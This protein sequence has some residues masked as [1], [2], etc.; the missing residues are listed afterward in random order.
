MVHQERQLIKDKNGSSRF[1]QLV[2]HE[3]NEKQKALQM[4]RLAMK[5]KMSG[6][7]VF[8]VQSFNQTGPKRKIS[9]NLGLA[10]QLTKK[11]S[12]EIIENPDEDDEGVDSPDIRDL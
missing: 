3:D 11:H 2:D 8:D 7:L 1:V 4:K 12:K 6:T 9:S 5:K 10:R